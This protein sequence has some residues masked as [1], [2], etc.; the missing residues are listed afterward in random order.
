MAELTK[1]S[2]LQELAE[3]LRGA[4][5]SP[6]RRALWTD[7]PEGYAGYR[8]QRS[9]V[10]QKRLAEYKIH[11]LGD[12]L[13]PDGSRALLNLEGVGGKSL[14]A[15][16]RFFTENGFEPDWPMVDQSREYHREN[17]SR[18]RQGRGAGLSLT[19]A[20]E[21]ADK[22]YAAKTGEPVGEFSRKIKEN[23]QAQKEGARLKG[24]R[25]L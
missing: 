20:I 19:R 25:T 3:E 6:V 21:E 1:E 13:T 8:R 5:T 18:I 2:T 11:T 24:R 22:Q 15:L 9:E 23:T 17:A 14:M 16:Q 4:A 12:L 7:F 10:N